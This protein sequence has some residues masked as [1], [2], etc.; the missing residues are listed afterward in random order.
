MGKDGG[1]LPKID[2]HDCKHFNTTYKYSREH[3]K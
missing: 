2:G 3:Q 1:V